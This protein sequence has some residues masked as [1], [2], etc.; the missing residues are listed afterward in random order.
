MSSFSSS[1]HSSGSEMARFTSSA[2][3]RPHDSGEIQASTRVYLRGVDLVKLVE[4]Y[5]R[6]EFANLLT[7]LPVD[8]TRLADLT[9]AQQSIVTVRDE[10][11]TKSYQLEL[12][13]GEIFSCI[14]YKV[15]NADGRYGV[16]DPALIRNSR[17]MFCLKKIGQSTEAMGIPIRRTLKKTSTG[18]ERI[19][20]HMIDIFC[21]MRC[22]YGETRRRIGNPLYAHS[23]EY[24]AEIFTR[25]TGQDFSQ[26]KPSSDPRLLKIMN[27]PMSWDEYHTDSTTFSERPGNIYFVPVIEYLEQDPTLPKAVGQ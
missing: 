21:R 16:F 7:P 1:S 12:S 4:R 5:L 10:T 24:L 8:S 6:G 2:G 3:G 17:C 18:E 23:I 25:S 15:Y 13:P 9:S 19:Y 14:G 22:V 26:L 20:Y 27:G 11:K